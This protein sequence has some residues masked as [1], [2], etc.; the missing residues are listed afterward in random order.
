MSVD[1]PFESF[2]GAYVLGSLSSED[3]QAFEAHLE[4]CM[5]CSASVADL[6]GLPGLLSQVSTDV[7]VDE[8]PPEG[9]LTSIVARSR[10]SR[11]RRLAITAGSAVVAVASAGVLA[12][13]LLTSGSSGDPAGVSMTAL[14]GYP[15]QGNVALADQ[16]WGTSVAMSCSYGGNKAHDYVL[17]AIGRNGGTAELATWHAMPADTARIVVGTELRRADI[18]ALEVRTTSGVALLRLTP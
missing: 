5:R 4:S 18:K 7:A 9:L 13:S 2:D 1:D 17:V 3:R 12:V 11:R 8:R 14:G 6:A 10:R 16:N 15:V